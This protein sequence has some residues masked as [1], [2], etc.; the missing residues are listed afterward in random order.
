M[1]TAEFIIGAIIV[2]AGFVSSYLVQCEWYRKRV[3]SGYWKQYNT[4]CGIAC[5]HAQNAMVILMGLAL[6]L[7]LIEFDK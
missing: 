1:F 5:A 7:G 4:P 6:C 2:A 3:F